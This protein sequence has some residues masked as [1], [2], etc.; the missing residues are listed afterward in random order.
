M[1]NIKPKTYVKFILLI[2]IV[3]TLYHVM[4]WYFWDIILKSN[5]TFCLIGSILSKT[6]S[7][8]FNLHPVIFTTMIYFIYWV[9][10]L[11]RKKYRHVKNFWNW[12]QNQALDHRLAVTKSSP[13]NMLKA[14]TTNNDESLWWHSFWL[15]TSQCN[16]RQIIIYV[17]NAI[18]FNCI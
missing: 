5:N 8:V 11:W 1:R 14:R 13:L 4:N 10:F 17:C 16:Q 7:K 3:A 2:L 12:A 9:F 15:W 6:L 18:F